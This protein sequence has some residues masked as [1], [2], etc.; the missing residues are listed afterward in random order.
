MARKNSIIIFFIL[1][2]VS[3]VPK[4]GLGQGREEFNGPFSSWADVKKR[5]GAKGNGKDDDTKA[6]QQAL[7]NLSNPTKNFNMGS[8]KYMVLYL[9]A[10]TYS[11]SSTLVLKGKIGVSIVGEDPAR[12]FIKWVGGDGDTI[13]WANASAY[14]KIGRLTWD[15]N[16]R[17]KMQGIG[18]HW[19]DVWR[20]EISQSYASLNI[21]LSDNWFVGGFE[22]GIS[23]GTYGSEGTGNNDSEITIRRCR[24][25]ACTDGG[26]EIH[27]YNALDY[28]IWDCRFERCYVGI[29]C[30]HGNFHAYRCFFSSSGGFDLGPDNCYYSSVRGCYSQNSYGFSFDQGVSCNPFKRVYVDNTV[31]NL[32]RYPIEFYHTGKG[33]FWDNRIGKVKDTADYVLSIGSFD[34]CY[35]NYQVMSINNSYGSAAP[36]HSRHKLDNYTVN[37]RLMAKVVADSAGFVEKMDMTPQRVN[38]Q[39]FEVPESAPS[40][41]IQALIDRAA[42]LKG[43]RPIVH[44]GVG[45]HYLD[46]TLQIPSGTDMQLIGDGMLYS[47]MLLR[48][49]QHVLAGSPLISVKGPSAVTLINLQIGSEADKGQMAGI[50]F[51]NIDQP[52]SEAHIDQVSSSQADTSL[53]VNGMDYINIQKDNSFFMTGN[54]VSGGKLTQQGKGT[55]MVNCFGGQFARLTVQKNGRF[56]ARDCWWEGGDR[57]PLDLSGSGSISVDGAMI[58]PAKVDSMPTVKIGKFAGNISLMNMY[59]QGGILVQPD[60][61]SLNLLVW[62]ILF[63]HKMDVLGFLNSK[64]NY[65]GAFLGLNAQCFNAKDTACKSIIPIRDRTTNIQ[66]LNSFLDSQT[67][68][69]RNDKP[70]IFKNLPDGISNIFISRVYIGAVKKSI[71]FQ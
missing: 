70:R 55:A 26:I 50:V 69:D 67:Q 3:F 17:K 68:E 63:Y 13:L 54:Y 44:F 43:Q 61:P 60:N 57:V 64:A 49:D 2:L 12:T 14:F 39:V 31:V 28:W 32:K 23:C 25:Y 62:N 8:G 9:P 11:I 53:V 37:D 18:I 47:S 1:T 65:K 36:F 40:S 30:A 6:F 35:A 7:D 24:F 51:E 48:K 27:G 42:S 45:T 15:A 38:R 20:N 41:E 4:R 16:G 5:F 71:V 66:Q 21:E 19:K 34:W 46:R 56:I 33:T 58:A 22:H 52:R 10:G 29:R 59:L